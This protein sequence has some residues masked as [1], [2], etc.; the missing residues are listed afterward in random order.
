MSQPPCRR[1]AR[2]P[3]LRGVLAAVLLLGAAA[4]GD[5]QAARAEPGD[6][7]VFWV[8]PDSA[9]ARQA[10]EWW[11]QGRIED[12]LLIERIAGRPQ[13]VWVNDDEPGAA[14]R[15]TV[16][17]AERADRTALLVAYFIPNRDCD[18]YSSGGAAMPPTTARGSTTSP[19]A[20]A[21]R[22]RT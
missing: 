12:A 8:D 13:A 2:F 9:A 3:L 4:F 15:A 10:D 6:T 1:L 14:V 11:Q 16:E 20:S 5:V 19:R 7:P 18:G 22:A 21:P 17:A